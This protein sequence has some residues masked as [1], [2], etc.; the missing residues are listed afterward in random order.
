M[1]LSCGQEV[2][3]YSK[4]VGYRDNGPPAFAV[5]K[6]NDFTVN[7][8][9]NELENDFLEAQVNNENNQNNL[10]SKNQ[11][12][13]LIFF[14]FLFVKQNIIDSSPEVSFNFDFVI[15][16]TLSLPCFPPETFSP[17]KPEVLIV[18]VVHN[19]DLSNS[20]LF[21]FSVHLFQLLNY[22]SKIRQLSRI[23]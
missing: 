14:S 6:S 9:T 5:A 15:L 3:I 1:F 23:S 13:N 12:K 2:T 7:S 4:P 17:L 8:W 16:Q 11:K 22:Y 10:D 18:I 21:I 19:F 20:I